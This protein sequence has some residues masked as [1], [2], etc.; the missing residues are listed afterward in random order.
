MDLS[1]VGKRALVGGASAGIGHAVAKE[2]AL[3]GAQVILCGR[4][5]DR[6]ESLAKSLNADSSDR[7]TVLECDW[8][9]TESTVSAVRELL[10]AGPIEILIGNSGGPPG[11]PLID[12]NAE[13]F[14]QAVTRLVW[15]PHALLQLLLPGM[16]ERSYGRLV[17]IVS[18]SVYEPIPNL[19]VSNTTR[20]ATASWAKTLSKE[21]PPGVTVNN[22]LPGF[23]D[24]ERLDQLRTGAAKRL[25]VSED[26]ANAKWLALV[27]E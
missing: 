25:G 26:E 20:G 21:L 22:V 7:A 2:L 4:R 19:G 8:N 16:V 18:T 27:P 10:A 24:T 11:G 23:T 17:N 14:H 9:D 12:A 3:N 5:R 15:T 1:L 6:L 13:Q